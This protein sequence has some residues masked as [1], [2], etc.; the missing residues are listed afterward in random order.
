MA[1]KSARKGKSAKKGARK[2]KK[3]IAGRAA[4][5]PV[6]PPCDACGYLAKVALPNR[7]PP[8]WFYEMHDAVNDLWNA[9]IRLE[10]ITHEGRT[11]LIGQPL[12]LGIGGGAKTPPPPPPMFP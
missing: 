6:R 5:R 4:S 7:R 2:G 3:S 11:D 12:L 9:V 1:T 8:T 10:K